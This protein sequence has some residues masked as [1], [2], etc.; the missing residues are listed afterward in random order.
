MKYFKIFNTENEYLEYISSDEFITPNVSTLYDSTKTWI[1]AEIHDYSKDYFT[2]KSLADEN[3][4]KITRWGKTGNTEYYSLDS[5]TTWTQVP[6]GTSEITIATI[7]SG[8]TLM[9]KSEANEW[10]SKWN[11][12]NSLTCTKNYDVYGNIMSLI[13]G[14]DFNGKTEIKNTS[15][16]NAGTFC[17]LFW[18]TNDTGDTAVGST[19][20]ISA[21]NLVLPATTLKRNTYY[22]LFRGCT[23]LK[24]PPKELPATTLVSDCYRSM[25]QGC[26]SLTTAPELSALNL[27]VCC[28][29][30][31]FKGCTS[32]TVAP[33]LHATTLAKECCYSMFQGCTSLTTAPSVLPATT[34][35][36]DCY[37]SMF[38]DCTSLTVAPKL[39]ATTLS[40]NCYYAMFQGCTSLTT[41]PELL[42]T[43]LSSG[44][45]RSMFQGCTSLTTAPS[46][47]PATTL[48]SDCY[49]SMFKG[50]TS[51]TTA[52]ELLAAKL[53]NACYYEM[54]RGCS[55]LNYIKCLATDISA[56][57]CTFAWVVGVSSNGEF[58]KNSDM[59]NWGRGNE[60]VPNNW[61]IIDA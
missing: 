7:N 20:L 1:T 17:A 59:T 47:L 26:T 14:D 57:N 35:A 45:Y 31:M 60:G 41:A 2:I 5:G 36:S 9:I 51:L 30:N 43:T 11:S 44:C 56:S 29:Q 46:V 52:P 23:N 38:Q 50:C 42:A 34:L 16:N 48:A 21:E 54:L 25:F 39:P 58:V 37:R 13:Y 18:Y 33:E 53:E 3:E 27:E 61:T 22:E 19:T 6:T 28:Y 8:E 55:N 15:S 32:L 4:V 49:R 40:S 12:H 24:Y 10:A